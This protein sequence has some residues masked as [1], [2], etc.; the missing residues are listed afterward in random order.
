[1][2]YL[3]NHKNEL[4]VPNGHALAC[5]NERDDSVC[6]PVQ[7]PAADKLRHTCHYFVANATRLQRK[8]THDKSRISKR[9][10]LFCANRTEQEKKKNQLNSW[11]K[12]GCGPKGNCPSSSTCARRCKAS[13]SARV[14][15]VSELA[16]QQRPQHPAPVLKLHTCVQRLL[17]SEDAK[18]VMCCT[19]FF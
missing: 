5:L 13:F 11:H 8:T 3:Q 19:F 6:Q 12:P 10:F 18:S 9:C 17:R 1:M 4:F 15:L 2:V 14:Q 7:V 16:A